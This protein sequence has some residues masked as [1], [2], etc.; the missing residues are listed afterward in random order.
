[1][2]RRVDGR[3]RRLAVLDHAL[4]V[5]IHEPVHV[6]AGPHRG[7][8]TG[9]VQAREALSELSVHLWTG[10][11]IQMLVDHDKT[12]DHGPAGEVDHPGAF[13]R[14]DRRRLADGGDRRVADD[15]RLIV[16]RGSTGSVND[17]DVSE[18]DNRVVDRHEGPDGGAQRWPLSER[19]WNRRH[20]EQR[21]NAW[22]D[23][24]HARL[25]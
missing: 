19:P 15:K 10:R 6:A 23:A 4:Q 7:H 1:M 25:A 24:R 3:P 9:E 17:A 22:E 8:A 16:F 11:V 18:S 21:R 2:V 13:R 20:N 5:Q 14:L 12:R